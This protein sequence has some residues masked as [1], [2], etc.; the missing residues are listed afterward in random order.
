[1]NGRKAKKTRR[2]VYGDYSHQ[3][4]EYR[5]DKNGTVY[6]VGLRRAYQE[7]KKLNKRRQLC[8]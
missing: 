6:C 4:R 8:H 1:M 2:L 5:K 3:L 7:A